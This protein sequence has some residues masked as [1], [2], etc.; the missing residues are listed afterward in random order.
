MKK[1]TKDLIK[2][3]SLIPVILLAPLILVIS[4]LAVFYGS[5]FV[6]R[7]VQ[8]YQ[9]RSEVFAYV[10]EHKES[11]EL[12]DPEYTQH[13]EYTEWGFVDAGVIYGYAYYPNDQYLTNSKKYRNGYR[14]EGPTTYG[15]GWYYYEKICDNWYYYE[16]HYG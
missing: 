9:I 15:N 13:F 3:I 11:I 1:N 7:E 14:L 5:A 16:E 6:V 12:S 2:A 4:L 8:H 10:E